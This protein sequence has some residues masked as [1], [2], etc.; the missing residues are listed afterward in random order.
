MWIKENGWHVDQG[1]W[2]ARTG[3]LELVALEIGH[4][5]ESFDESPLQELR[6]CFGRLAHGDMPECIFLLLWLLGVLDTQ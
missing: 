2:V 3:Y 6:E 5:W 4:F 1:E